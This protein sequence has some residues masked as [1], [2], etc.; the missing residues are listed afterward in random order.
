MNPFV[1]ILSFFPLQ[2]KA[3]TAEQ[4]RPFA[5]SECLGFPTTSS[6][7]RCSWILDSLS[8]ELGFLDFGFH[9]QKFLAFWNADSLTW[10]EFRAMETGRFDTNSSS[11]IAQL[12]CSL[13]V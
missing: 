1:T 3:L 12:F 9:K 5:R 10:G 11:E 6:N 13:Q 4:Q 2:A 8:V 7:P